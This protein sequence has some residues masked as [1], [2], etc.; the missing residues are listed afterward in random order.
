M[1]HEG[2]LDTHGRV[3][4]MALARMPRFIPWT[5]NDYLDLLRKGVM[6]S[7]LMTP[8]LREASALWQEEKK[9]STKKTDSNTVYLPALRRVR[10]AAALSQDALAAKAKVSRDT[11]AAAEA[12]KG[13]T[14]AVAEALA[15]AAG[16]TLKYLRYGP[17]E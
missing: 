10:K 3:T 7:G 12:G 15:A 6:F 11:L 1:Q 9:M 2:Y 8:E 16:L 17:G 13:V 5:V 14:R 4:D